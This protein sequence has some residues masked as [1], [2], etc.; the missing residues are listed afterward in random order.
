MLKR[1]S[2]SG[3]WCHPVDSKS[4][5]CLCWSLLIFSIKPNFIEFTAKII[6][7]CEYMWYVHKATSIKHMHMTSGS[8]QAS[9]A[10]DA[11]A[12]VAASS[13]ACG[14]LPH[15]FKQAHDTLG[16]EAIN[17]DFP[18]R[19]GLC[20][21]PSLLEDLPKPSRC[22]S[23]SQWRALRASIQRSFLHQ[24]ETLGWLLR[25]CKYMQIIS[26]ILTFKEKLLG[27]IHGYSWIVRCSKSLGKA[28][29][30]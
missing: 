16:S 5:S 13:V 11:F 22:P 24:L 18:P 20:P 10:R 15:R 8:P 7:I 17:Q 12:C 9:W 26:K 2:T 28:L 19:V 27:C 4:F 30:C 3:C 23:R 29:H 6:I 1:Y 25:A 14:C 21:L